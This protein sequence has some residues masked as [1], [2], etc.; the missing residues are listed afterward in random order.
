MM[1]RVLGWLLRLAGVALF[2]ITGI[3]AVQFLA[4]ADDPAAQPKY[5]DLQHLNFTATG[6]LPVK[7][8]Y[9]GNGTV[10]TGAATQ[11]T[12]RTVRGA[13]VEIAVNGELVPAR[14]LGKMTIEKDGTTLYDYYGVLIHPG[15]NTIVATAIGMNGKRGAPQSETVYGPGPAVSMHVSLVGALVADGKS[16]ARLMIDAVDQWNNPA[17]AGSEVHAS[18]VSGTV[19][20]GNAKGVLGATPS[21]PPNINAVAPPTQAPQIDSTSHPDVRYQLLEGGR[22]FIPVTASLQSGAVQVQVAIGSIIDTATFQVAPYLR[23]PFVNGVVS[24]GA[25][26]VPAAVDGE[27]RYDTGG[28][29]K[30]RV[31]VFASGKVGRASSLTL[32]YESQN[33]LQQ[34]SVTGPFVADPNERPYQTYGDTSSISSDFHSSDRLYAR[35]DNGRNN[36]MWGEYQTAV[37][38]PGGLAAYQ[39]QVSG[40]KGELGLGSTGRGRLMGFNARDQN[41]YISFTV[42]VSGLAAL[43]QPLHANIVIGSDRITLVALDRRTGVPVSQTQET[44]NVDYTID[45]ATGTLRFINVPLPFDFNFNP[46]VLYIQYEYSGPDVKSETTGFDFR[47][48]LDRNNATKV[49]LGYINDATGS[50]NY[51]LTTQ[52]IT[53]RMRT[54][55]WR[56]SHAMSAGGL[57]TGAFGATTLSA[58]GSATSFAL[59]QRFSGNDVSFNYDNTGAGFINPFGGFSATGVENIQTSF[60]HRSKDHGGIFVSAS[61]V[62]NTG[63]GQHSVQQTVTA[64]WDSII[65]STLSVTLGMQASRQTNGPGAVQ[66]GQGA[67]PTISGST[68]QMQAGLRWKP[69]RAAQVSVQHETSLGGNSAILPS[70]TTV[71]FDYDLP[72]QGRMYLRELLGGAAGSFAS[73]TASYTA[74]AIGSHSTQI[75]IQRNVGANTA[76]DTSYVISNG[77]NATNIYTTLGIQENFKFGKH[78]SGNAMFQN[79]RGTGDATS[80]FTVFGTGLTYALGNDFRSSFSLQSRGGIGGGSTLSFGAAGHIGP[81]IALIGNV[82]ETMSQTYMT[83]DD[84]IS[85]AF[86]PSENDRLVSLLGFDRTAGGVNGTQG[87]ADVLSFEEVYRPTLSTEITGRLGYKLNG[88]GIYLAHSSVMGLRLT[89]DLGKRFDIGAEARAMSAGST[90]LGRATDFATEFGYKAPGGTRVATGYNFSGSVDPTLTGHPVRKG[91]Y[92]TVTTLIDRIFG[93]GKP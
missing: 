42:P 55:E 57:P 22:V 3:S 68:A 52:T 60:S 90:L 54:G 44:R 38:D 53:S 62:R 11:V 81:N 35:I 70:Q 67:P 83:A 79:A 1:H 85:F 88:D 86:R 27:G 2:C 49:D 6:D 31:A 72:R 61:Q 65:S 46:Q 33:R 77:G 39:R 73:S 40:V 28:A 34:S 92:V 66:A 5:G 37:G 18:I 84:R 14:N 32:S 26:S 7:L 20:L 58:H 21:P 19:T 23:A 24:I 12:V 43:L 10:V 45:Y 78:L 9:P 80:G 41:A 51:S 74:P 69:T 48:A 47:Y 16:Q 75:G 59:S 56:L 87:T 50:M 82:N 25:G 71:E 36:L 15:P 89:Q 63:G 30:G 29:R 76:V 8:T 91:F 64:M 93:W 17:M 4:P 13:G